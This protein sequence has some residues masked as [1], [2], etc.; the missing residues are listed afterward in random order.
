MIL[1]SQMRWEALFDQKK[2]KGR[3]DGSEEPSWKYQSNQAVDMESRVIQYPFLFLKKDRLKIR[4]LDLEAR[5][6]G[7]REQKG[8]NSLRL[9]PIFDRWKSEIFN[10]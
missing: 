7:T 5:K 10:L 9:F 1:E 4:T 3:S 2:K 8:L 6:R